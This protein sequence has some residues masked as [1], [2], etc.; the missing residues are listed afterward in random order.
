[1]IPVIDIRNDVKDT[2]FKAISTFGFFYVVG[3]DLPS[4]IIES[5]FETSKSFFQ[6]DTKDSFSYNPHTNQGYVSLHR[7]RLNQ[8]DEDSK[9]AFNLTTPMTSNNPLPPS[10][11]QNLNKLHQF[12]LKLH[13]LGMSI[14]RSIA[15]SMGLQ[16][17]YFE[18]K[19]DMNKKSGTILRFLCYPITNQKE[20]ILAGAHSD[21]GTLTLLL[22]DHQG[23][24]EVL[25]NDEWISLPPVPGSIIVNAGDLFDFWTSGS[26]KS[27]VHRVVRV[28]EWHQPRYSIAFFLH[29]DDDTSLDPINCKNNTSSGNDNHSSGRKTMTAREHLLFK[30]QKS[31]NNNNS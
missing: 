16:H 30:L 11:Q 8:K 10:F 19:H 12:H 21:Y 14:L 2:I 6:S 22:Q 9:E 23:G 15:E 17:D 26:I 29:P 20:G 4:E 3:H 24:L 25:L 28:K 27:A 13:E 1:M 31:Y 5:M 18:S 7:E